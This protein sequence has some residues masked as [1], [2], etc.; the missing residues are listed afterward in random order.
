METEIREAA[1]ILAEISTLVVLSGAGVG[2]ES[3]IPTFRE[4]QTGL[5]ARY[6]P[7]QLATRDAFRRNPQLV[8]DWYEY[9]RELV[10][11]AQLNPGHQALA[12]LERY[13]PHVIVLTQ[14]IDGLHQEAGSS[15]VVELHGNIRRSKC[16]ADCHGEPTLVNVMALPDREAE[17]AALSL[18]RGP[19]PAGC[20]LVRRGFA[21]GGAGAG[22]ASQRRGGYD[23]GGGDQRRG[24]SGRGAAPTCQGGGKP[25]N[26]SEPG[27]KRDHAADG[28]FS[29]GSRR[30]GL[31]PTL[32]RIGRSEA[33]RLL[34][35][36]R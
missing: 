31:A 5:W 36:E 12:E 15:D 11:R 21:P 28:H 22:D 20:G 1:A 35:T 3:G 25:G 9:R 23:A 4:A 34:I 29:T 33:G 14:N 26:R 2:K 27:G 10:A 17:P 8:W 19:C 16:F 7:Q 6:D 32:G 24:L 30:E 18:L 13:I